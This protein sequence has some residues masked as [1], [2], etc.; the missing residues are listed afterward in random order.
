MIHPATA[1]KLINQHKGYGVFATSFIPKGTITYVKDP[2]EIAVTQA[3]YQSLSIPMQEQV[4]K[5]SYIDENGNRILSWDLGKYVNHC[6][7]PNTMSSG[8]GFEIALRDIVEGEEITDEYGLFNLTE[9][10]QVGCDKPACRCE[11]LPNDASHFADSWDA[12]LKPALKE[13]LI[14]EQALWSYVDAK[15]KRQLIKLQDNP[16]LYRSVRKLQYQANQ[17]KASLNGMKS[18]AA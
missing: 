5:Y 9:P 1:L 8:Y 12:K 13:V 11:V 16:A 14:V 17:D 3:H 18:T 10:M 6:C 7:D 2:L 4:E 15:T